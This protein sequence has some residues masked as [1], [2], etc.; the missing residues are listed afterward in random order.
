MLRGYVLQ[1]SKG[2]GKGMGLYPRPIYEVRSCRQ[3]W[4]QSGLSLTLN[5]RFPGGTVDI[6]Q[7][8]VEAGSELKAYLQSYMRR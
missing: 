4:A 3:S 1:A 7:A 2:S 6:E 8:Q 5:S